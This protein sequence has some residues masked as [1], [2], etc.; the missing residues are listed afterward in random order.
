MQVVIGA[1]PLGR[2]IAHDLA[3]RGE[4][5]RLVSRSGGSAGDPLIEWVRADATKP[6]DLALAV[7]GSTVVYQCAQ[8]QYQDWE[9]SFPQLQRGVVEAAARAG[10]DLVIADNLYMYG[11]PDGAPISESSIQ[12]PATV[13]GGV[14][15]SMAD[16]ALAAHHSGM[17]RVAI[18]RASTYFGPGHDQSSKA[19]FSEAL[20]GKPMR[21]LGR[22]DM[23]HSLSYVPDAAHAMVAL[24]TGDS[25]W[26]AAWISP[27]QPAITQGE[28]AER[29]WAASGNAGPMRVTQVSRL[30]LGVLGLVVPMIREVPEMLYQHEKPFVVDSSHFEGEFGLRATP[31]ADAI[32]STLEWYSNTAGVRA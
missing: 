32:A 18:S 21:F 29:V 17:L 7:R 16:E 9:R 15:K 31:M 20:R 27:V 10:A 2:S 23:P 5:V 1:G 14:R 22:M 30:M 19:I 4:R 25:G 12:Q 6:P 8:P 24:G 28:F 11:D 26:G 3:A 13:K